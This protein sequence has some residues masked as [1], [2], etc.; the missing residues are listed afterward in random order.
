M[1]RHH[2]VMATALAA[3]V[4]IATA[5][6]LI[7]NGDS[8][9]FYD[10]PGDAQT[11]WYTTTLVESSTWK[12][13]K[14]PLGIGDSTLATVL[15][16]CNKVVYY[17]RHTV[18]LNATYSS[19]SAT[20][21]LDHGAAVFLN[22]KEIFRN[23]MPTGTLLKT[24]FALKAVDTTKPNL[25]TFTFDPKLLLKGSNLFAVEVHNINFQ[26]SACTSRACSR[27]RRVWLSA[28]H[29]PR[30]R[31]CSCFRQYLCTV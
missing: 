4:A 12:S 13:G 9:R 15:K 17:L 18:T 25:V 23:N 20:M 27:S 10:A 30:F 21:T 6:T 26:V 5:D 1:R 7:P 2:V 16:N 11:G 22:G 8:W 29:N 31:Q 28:A 19:A 24:T 3:V 14:A